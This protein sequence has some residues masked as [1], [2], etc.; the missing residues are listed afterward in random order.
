MNARSLIGPVLLAALVFAGCKKDPESAAKPAGSESASNVS[1]SSEVKRPDRPRPD[2]PVLPRRRPDMQGQPGDSGP[3]GM[4]ADGERPT[5]EEMLARRDARRQE[6][7]DM[8]DADHDGQLSDEERN[9]MHEARM[10]GV[11]QKLDDDGDGRL[12]RTE[13]S[14]MRTSARRPMPDFDT[15]DTDKDGFISVEELAV[16][17]PARGPGGPGG[18]GWRGGPTDKAEGSRD[19]P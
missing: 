4:M 10:S 3:P 18:R 11:V 12:S 2:L 19:Q 1:T 15:L 9:M 8:Y 14:E 5:R 16:G 13:L 7:L 6:M 17:R